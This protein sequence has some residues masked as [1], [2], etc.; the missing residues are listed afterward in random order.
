M[1][2]TV[3]LLDI[4]EVCGITADVGFSQAFQCSVTKMTSKPVLLS[5][6]QQLLAHFLIESEGPTFFCALCCSNE[7][8]PKLNQVIK[9]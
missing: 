4:G 8:G 1:K 6:L 9:N 2:K 3:K 5:A 7:V